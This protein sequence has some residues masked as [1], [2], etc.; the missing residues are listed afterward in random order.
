M[1]ETNN[2]FFYFAEQTSPDPKDNPIDI[3]VKHGPGGDWWIEFDTILH[4]FEFMNRNTRQ[5]LGDNIMEC[6]NL[7]KIQ[8]MLATDD[9]FGE[10]DHPYPAIKGENLSEKRIRTIE[11]SRRSHKIRNPR[12]EGNKLYGHIVTAGGEVGKGFANEIIRGMIPSF[13]CRCFGVMRLING[14]PTI[15]VRMVVTYDW[16]L[17]P[18]F[19]AAKMIGTPVAKSGS[20]AF[21]EDADT[22]IATPSKDIAIPFTELALDIAAKDGGISAYMESFDCGRD[23]IIGVTDDMQRAVIAPDKD[24]Y[25]YAKMDK[26]TVDMVRDFYNSFH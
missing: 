21:T 22:G 17:Y 11:L 7:D 15:V 18:G 13:S 25:I 12:R 24:H 20:V 14:K 9:W 19:E 1:A 16:V 2:D 4:L 8:S 26:N 10:M 3:Q 23:S 6:L 5:Y